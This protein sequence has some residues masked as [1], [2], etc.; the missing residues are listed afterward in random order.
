[1]SSGRNPASLKIVQGGFQFSCLEFGVQA[2]FSQ[3]GGLH[4]QAQG[5]EVGP[6]EPPGHLPGDE[7]GMEAVGGMEPEGAA[8][9][10]QF[11]QDDQQVVSAC[12]RQGVIVEGRVRQAQA[13][14]PV[15]QFLRHRQGGAAPVDRLQLPGGAVGRSPGGSPGR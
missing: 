5:G 4:P 7:A 1:M 15:H 2:V 12:T 10:G 8:A 3:G 9:A 6:L 13:V 14:L 11:F